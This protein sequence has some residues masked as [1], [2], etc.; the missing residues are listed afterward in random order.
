[1]DAIRLYLDNAPAY[2]A[3]ITDDLRAYL[4]CSRMRL[5]VHILPD[6]VLDLFRR[7]RLTKRDAEGII[8]T[9][10]SRYSEGVVAHSRAQLMEV[11]SDDD[12]AEDAAT[13]D[14]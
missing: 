11:S 9:T 14:C 1:M 13:G 4:V 7:G 6:L 2:E 8:E 5:P 3:V 10:A 12:D